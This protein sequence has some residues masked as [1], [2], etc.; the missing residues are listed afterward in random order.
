M[1]VSPSTNCV[2][3]FAWHKTPTACL[4][5]NKV[6][7]CEFFNLACAY[8]DYVQYCIAVDHSA[9]TVTVTHWGPSSAFNNSILEVKMEQTTDRYRY[10]SFAMERNSRNE[11][12]AIWDL[13]VTT[14]EPERALAP[15]VFVPPAMVLVAEGYGRNLSVL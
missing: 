1:T 11:D 10:I 15:E 3:L 4:E 9:G 6:A 8:E 5:S 13:N 12:V 7:T 2:S 14:V